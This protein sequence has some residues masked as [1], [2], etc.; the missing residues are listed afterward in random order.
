M[1]PDRQC[2]DLKGSLNDKDY[3]TPSSADAPPTGSYTCCIPQHFLS[4]IL[5]RGKWWI[6]GCKGNEWWLRSTTLAYGMDFIVRDCSTSFGFFKRAQKVLEL[7]CAREVW[8]KEVHRFV[9][10][11]L[12]FS[13]TAHS[14]MSVLWLL[15]SNLTS[16]GYALYK[17]IPGIILLWV[18]PFYI[19][20]GKELNL[21]F[22]LKSKGAQNKRELDWNRPERRS[23]PPLAGCSETLRICSPSNSYYNLTFS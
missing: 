8:K 11:F 14:L 7:N 1:T 2:L 16:I 4:S 5:L 13:C 20:L 22:T 3:D 15:L 10:A 9:S 17:L 23:K 12:S 19:F 21:N 6:S 18:R